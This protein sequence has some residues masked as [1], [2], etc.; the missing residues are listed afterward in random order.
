MRSKLWA[1]QHR[2]APYLFVSPFVILF[3]VFMIYPLG[4][5]IMLSL[6]QTAGKTHQKFV[7]LDNYLFLMRDKYFWLAA[8]NTTALTIAYLIVQIPL[9][10]LLAI[11]VNTRWVKWKNFFRFAFFS[12][13]LVGSVFAAVLFSQLL[14]PSNGLLNRSLGLV[15]GHTPEIPWLTD[16]ILAR[17]S[18]LVAWVWLSVGWGMIYFLAALQSVDAELYEAADVDGASHWGKFLHITLPGIKPVTVFLLLIGTIGGFQLFEIPY[19][20]FPA[21]NGPNHAALTI[22][23]YLF[24]AGWDAGDLGYA[25]AIGW[26]LVL[27]IIMVSLAQYRLTMREKSLA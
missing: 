7:G 16:P 9:S 27:I 25:S 17:V 18:I 5:S 20:M 12:T 22:V 3:C 23:A 2:F 4:R 21:G 6:Y 14:N 13:Y 24:M 26:V 10:L 19:I 1:L 15:M 8:L 11:V